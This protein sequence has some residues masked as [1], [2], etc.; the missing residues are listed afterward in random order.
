MKWK[1]RDVEIPNRLVLA[2]MAGVTNEA[3]RIICKEMNAGLV[4]AEMVSDKAIG[5]K[6]QK[7]LKTP[8]SSQ[9]TSRSRS[10]RGP[11]RLR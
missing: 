7:T 10:P 11:E 9:R 3:F 2:P 8:S 5:F 1:I 6:N 4:M